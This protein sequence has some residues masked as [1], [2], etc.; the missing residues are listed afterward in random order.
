MKKGL[1]K[2]LLFPPKC[3]SCSALIDWYEG[4]NGLCKN[5]LE[6][7]ELAK[8]ES[9][10]ICGA[11]VSRCVCVTEEMKH[12][13]CADFRKLTFY[14]HATRDRVQ[15]RVLYAIKERRTAQTHLFLANELLPHLRA[16][17]EAVP[18]GDFCMVWL[19]RTREAKKKYGTDQAEELVRALSRVSGIPALRALER[20]GG[21]VQKDLSATARIKNAKASFA[22]NESADVRGKTVILVDDLVTTGAGMAA[23]AKL[24]RKHGAINV[25]CIAVASDD[26]NREIT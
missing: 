1:W 4:T 15:N 25:H 22:W 17:T 2:R 24:L 5:C 19:P 18:D 11:A 20:A 12:A 16:V 9:C 26:L 3:A 14:Y 21:T 8:R 7:W 6:Q 13:K 10:C 23:A